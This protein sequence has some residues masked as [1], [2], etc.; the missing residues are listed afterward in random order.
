MILHGP[1]GSN[2]QNVRLFGLNMKKLFFHLLQ[3]EYMQLK[4]KYTI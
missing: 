4:E 3:A 1:V 2:N